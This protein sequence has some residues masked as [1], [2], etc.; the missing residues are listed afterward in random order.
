[1]SPDGPTLLRTPPARLERAREHDHRQGEPEDENPS[2]DVRPRIVRI[3]GPREHGHRA[4]EGAAHDPKQAPPSPAQKQAEPLDDQDN[5]RY[6]QGHIVG[7]R[8]H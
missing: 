5:R 3:E 6:W 2:A 8:I 4:N 7:P 1:M